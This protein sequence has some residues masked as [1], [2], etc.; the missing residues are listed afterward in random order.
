M[1]EL[2]TL[3]VEVVAPPGAGV[4]SCSLGVSSG[5]KKYASGSCVERQKY[6]FYG[7]LVQLYGTSGT[8]VPLT[9]HMSVDISDLLFTS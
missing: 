4:L 5:T 1:F 7:Q 8:S 9:R 6:V 3:P 2:G